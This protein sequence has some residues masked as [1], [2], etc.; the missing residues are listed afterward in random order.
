MMYQLVTCGLRKGLLERHELVFEVVES[1]PVHEDIKLG[2]PKRDVYIKHY[3]ENI[4]RLAKHGVKVICY[5]FMPVL[6]WTRT[7]LDFS[8]VDRSTPLAYFQHQLEQMDI[9]K[10]PFSLPRWDTS[11]AQEEM[12]QLMADYRELGAMYLQGIWEG[13]HVQTKKGKVA[14]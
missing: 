7:Q 9:E 10:D 6:D 13:L 3:Q 11:Y 1:L 5:N 8:L 2:R 12:K 4:R 14:T